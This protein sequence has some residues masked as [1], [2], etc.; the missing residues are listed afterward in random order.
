MSGPGPPPPGDAAFTPPTSLED[1]S[2]RFQIVKEVGRGRFGEVS[3]A[4]HAPTQRQ[5]ALKRTAFGSAG[6]PELE[7][8]KVEAQALARLDHVN[9]VRTYGTWRRQ[10]ASTATTPPCSL[11]HV[12][13][14]ATC[15]AA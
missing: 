15:A 12:S 13:R 11:W 4:L 2:A 8:V 3:L 14:R 9:V 10:N 1:F 6:R 7:K 5:F